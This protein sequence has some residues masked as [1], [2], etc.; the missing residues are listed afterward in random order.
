MFNLVINTPLTNIGKRCKDSLAIQ[1]FSNDGKYS[2]A[3]P[4]LRLRLRGLFGI[5]ESLLE[6]STNQVFVHGTPGYGPKLV[7]MTRA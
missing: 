4:L 5:W 3:T 1:A 7:E 6:G 2:I